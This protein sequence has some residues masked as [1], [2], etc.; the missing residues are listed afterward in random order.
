MRAHSKGDLFVGRELMRRSNS[1]A[2]LEEKYVIKG[3]GTAK[4]SDME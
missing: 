1:S 2:P 3:R 4:G